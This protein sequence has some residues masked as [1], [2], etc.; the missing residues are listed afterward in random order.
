MSRYQN[1]LGTV[2][3]HILLGEVSDLVT[4]A[5]KSHRNDSEAPRIIIV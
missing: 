2:P 5:V 3:S 4:W 1:A